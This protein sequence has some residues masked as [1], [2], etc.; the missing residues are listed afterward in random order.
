ML[1]TCLGLK[2]AMCGACTCYVWGLYM[3]CVELAHAVCGICTCHVWDLHMLCMG[4]AHAICGACTCYVWSMQTLCYNAELVYGIYSTTVTVR[5]RCTPYSSCKKQL[6][7]ERF[8]VTSDTKQRYLVVMYIHSL[9]TF[10]N[11][12]P[13]AAGCSCHPCWD[14]SA[15]GSLGL[16]PPTGCHWAQRTPRWPPPSQLQGVAMPL[17]Q[18][19]VSINRK[20]KPCRQLPVADTSDVWM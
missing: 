17:L 8:F 3:L 19:P 6:Q 18:R 7:I 10:M 2:H 4:L 5:C 14:Q 15:Q 13:G 1:N 12:I 16:G 20:L 9:N 11:S